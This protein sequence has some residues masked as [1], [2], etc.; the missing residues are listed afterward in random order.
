MPAIIAA[1]VIRIGRRRSRT[2]W[3]PAWAA[4]CPAWRA[5]SANVISRIAFA[6]A[7]PMAMMA[8]MKD[9]TLSVVPVIQSAVATPAITAGTVDTTA[10]ASQTDWKLAAS[11]R[12]MTTTVKTRPVRRPSSICHRAAICPRTVAVTLGGRLPS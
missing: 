9:W 11:S 2:A 6:V 12:K 4:D 10:R 7:T 3:T 1:L 8:P 5:L